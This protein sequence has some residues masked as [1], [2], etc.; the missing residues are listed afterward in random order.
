MPSPFRTALLVESLGNILGG[1]GLLFTPSLQLS[2]ILRSSS[3][4]TPLSTSLAQ[5][6]GCVTLALAVP[7]LVAY[8]DT[9]NGVANRWGAYATLGLG[10]ALLVP[11]LIGW[12]AKGGGPFSDVFLLGGAGVLGVIFGGRMFVLGVRPDMMAAEKGKGA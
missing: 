4:I 2:F 3:S 12:W 1:L 9:P 5:M 11:T 7:L 8:P 6:L 10:E